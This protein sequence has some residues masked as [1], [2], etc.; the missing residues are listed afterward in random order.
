M[1]DGLFED[2]EI[3][4]LT[5]TS[6]EPGL[7]LDPD[8]ATVSI[9]NDDREYITAVPIMVTVITEMFYISTAI[10]VGLT[11]TT[12]VVTEGDGAFVEVCARV[13]QGE[14]ERNAVVTLQT[15]DGSALSQGTE[16]DYQ[17][18]TVQLTFT[19]N[20]TIICQSI[21]IIND[22]FYE[23]SED[24]NV[25]L[26]TVDPDV[27]LIPDTGAITILDEDGLNSYYKPLV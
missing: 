9:P 24:F 18:L 22:T 3:Y 4:L 2:E 12:F 23:N 6:D 10:V 11:N 21:I 8:Q 20:I 16:P 13:F 19:P 27:N 25:R 7:T 5:L 1:D 15:M 26:T 14:L 17:S